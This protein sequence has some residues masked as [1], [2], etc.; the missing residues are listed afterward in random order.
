MER[1]AHRSERIAD[2]G[3]K[4]D[5]ELV[6]MFRESSLDRYLDRRDG[7]PRGTSPR[8]CASSLVPCLVKRSAGTPRPG[9]TGEETHT[10][11]CASDRARAYAPLLP[12]S[13][14]PRGASS[15]YRRRRS[16]KSS[17]S[18][19]AV[20]L[21]LGTKRSERWYALR[22]FLKASISFT[23]DAPSGETVCLLSSEQAHTD[24][25]TR[26]IRVLSTSPVLGFA[27]WTS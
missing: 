25:S 15:E 24:C 20:M 27:H 22:Y 17:L 6:S 18:F 14:P 2:L 10:P 4:R 26:S 9:T 5:K 21:V 13:L 1:A 16:D 7:R 23:G 12:L 8:C 19:S 3:G 11:C